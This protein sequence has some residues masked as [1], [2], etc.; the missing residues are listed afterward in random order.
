[1][2]SIAIETGID[3]RRIWDGLIAFMRDVPSAFPTGKKS[4][5]LALMAYFYHAGK[6]LQYEVRCGD[7]AKRWKEQIKL[8]DSS[9]PEAY[10]HFTPRWNVK[11][12][13][14]FDTCWLSPGFDVLVDGP[15]RPA[16]TERRIMLAF[17]HE[18]KTYT[19]RRGT[20]LKP[21]LDEVRKIGAVRTHFKV[22]S[23]FSSQLEA[24]EDKNLPLIQSEISRFPEAALLTDSWIVL[25][26]CRF[27][28]QGSYRRM[29]IEGVPRMF[30]RAMVLSG[31]GS[32]PSL[33]GEETLIVPGEH[34]GP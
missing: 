21:V 13:L 5:S 26:L 25:Q 28:R 14:E 3:P 15:A 8:A 9:F 18:E 4:W 27:A 2:S 6:E 31:D 11:G 22:L 33:L 17:E 10:R 16:P 23:F 7:W 30:L 12:L 1:M 29:M 34:R 19:A 32:Q 24:Q 20:E